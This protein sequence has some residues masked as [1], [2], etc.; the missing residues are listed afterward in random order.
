MTDK[1]FWLAV[2]SALLAMVKAI[3]VKYKLGSYSKEK[4][5]HSTEADGVT[6]TLDDMV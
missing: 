6:T 1:E 5:I 4:V 3:E 2:R